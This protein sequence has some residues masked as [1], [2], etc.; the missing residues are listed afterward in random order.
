[1]NIYERR[2][3]PQPL[4]LYESKYFAFQRLQK[5]HS[6]PGETV[7]MKSTAKKNI[8]K[9]KNKKVK[10]TKAKTENSNKKKVKATRLKQKRQSREFALKPRLS[11]QQQRQQQECWATTNAKKINNTTNAANV[12]ATR[13]HPLL[14]C[15]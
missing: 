10:N 5:W 2:S 4:N 12:P 6:K 3:L 13:Q 8:H 14:P 7:R 9:N 15:E 1:M 11:L